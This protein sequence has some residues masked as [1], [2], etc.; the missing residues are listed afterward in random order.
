MRQKP[1]RRRG[2]GGQCA[3]CPSSCTRTC[4]PPVLLIPA[5]A[6]RRRV[7]HPADDLGQRVY[8][9]SPSRRGQPQRGSPRGWL[10]NANHRVPESFRRSAVCMP[11][12]IVDARTSV[13]LPGRGERLVIESA[14]CPSFAIPF[15]RSGRSPR[16][17]APPPRIPLRV[18][19]HPLSNPCPLR[20]ARILPPLRAV[21]LC[22][23]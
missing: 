16:P 11:R 13:P 19:R 14:V 9:F 22:D 20:P 6:R 18:P 12:V 5:G 17:C 23:G 10:L 1:A 7:L 8:P 2:S 3:R 21:L 4:R 15:A